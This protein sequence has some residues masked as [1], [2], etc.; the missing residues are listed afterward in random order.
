MTAGLSSLQPNRTPLS[1]PPP[2]YTPSPPKPS[3]SAQCHVSKQ[4]QPGKG[5]PGGLAEEE[6]L[7]VQQIA[8]GGNPF[9]SYPPDG[10]TPPTLFFFF[11]FLA[12]FFFFWL[13]IPS[14]S[15]PMERCSSRNP[16]VCIRVGLSHRVQLS[17]PKL[18]A[19]NASF[20]AVL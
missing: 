16:W 2:P 7:L 17:V 14:F 4:I 10:S 15:T 5:W 6:R 12:F 18:H 20:V 13:L 8:A 3:P 19:N 1:P 9:P 11:L